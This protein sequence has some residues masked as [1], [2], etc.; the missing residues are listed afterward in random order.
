MTELRYN[1]LL[2]DWTM[3][4]S[5]RQ[6][7]PHLPEDYCPFCPGSGKVPDHYD[8]YVYNNDFPALSPSPPDPDP[9]S[10]AFYQVAPA[11]GKCEVILYSEDHSASLAKLPIEHIRRVVDVWT[12]RYQE[13][14]KDPR[15]KYVLIFENRGREVGVTMSHPH[16]QIYAYPYIPLKVGTELRATKA[17]Y[18]THGECLLCAINREEQQ[19]AARVIVETDNFIALRSHL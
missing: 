8:V 11:Y 10:T 16:G 6:G 2:Q 9:V 17:H 4:A 1:P 12:D 5:K 19:F 7:R 3:V 14:A 13:L 18:E 15:H